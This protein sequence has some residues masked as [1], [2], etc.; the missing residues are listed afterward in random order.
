[1]MLQNLK[2]VLRADPEVLADIIL[3]H[4]VAIAHLSKGFFG[5]FH[6]IDFSPVPYHAI[7]IDKNP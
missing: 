4:E 7:K 5:K 3:G 1:M 2:N 6:S